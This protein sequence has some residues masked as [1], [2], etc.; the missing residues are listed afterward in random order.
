MKLDKE[1][2]RK[3]TKDE[4]TQYVIGYLSEFH[5]TLVQ[6]ALNGGY[7]NQDSGQ[8]SAGYAVDVG[9]VAILRELMNLVDNPAEYHDR[10]QSWDEQREGNDGSSDSE[11]A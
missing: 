1:A 6:S 7:I 9:R 11:D 10:F 2:L 3:W 5:N 4:T 8:I